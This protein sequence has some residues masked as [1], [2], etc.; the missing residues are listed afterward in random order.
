M[1]FSSLLAFGKKLETDCGKKMNQEQQ[2][3]DGALQY[4]TTNP[5]RTSEITQLQNFQEYDTLYRYH[6]QPTYYA[7]TPNAIC[8]ATPVVQQTSLYNEF[9]TPEFIVQQLPPPPRSTEEFRPANNNPPQIILNQVPPQPREIV[10]QE[11]KEQ[12]DVKD[13]ASSSGLTDH[14]DVND[15][16]E[17]TP[18]K[19]GGNNGQP[20]KRLD[21][22]K[23]ATMRERRRLRKVNEAFE[24]VKQRTCSNPNQRLPKVEILRNAI[25]YIDKLE[26]TLGDLGKPTD[27]MTARNGVN[28]NMNG[29]YLQVSGPPFYKTRPP[30]IDAEME[31]E[32]GGYFR[33]SA[34][35]RQPQQDFNSIPSAPA[36]QPRKY[37][38]NNTGAPRAPRTPAASSVVVT[39]ASSVDHIS[40]DSQQH[41]EMPVSTMPE[42]TI[43]SSSSPPIIMENVKN[44]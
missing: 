38:R 14:S 40:M 5:V 18:T 43:V 2:S 36:P 3:Y 25:E 19:K 24:V 41:H 6:Q 13:D 35:F 15:S 7:Y 8:T 23:A 9:T 1:C 29:E 34:V 4:Y 33:Q 30:Y 17:T 37:R 11:K 12:F 22:R 39:S 20:T 28:I 27:I 10:K 21:R 16:L 31:D 42:T 44:E 32:N 26:R